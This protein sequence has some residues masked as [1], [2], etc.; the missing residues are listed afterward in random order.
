MC[1]SMTWQAC[2]AFNL[3]CLSKMSFLGYKHVYVSRVHCDSN[4]IS[5]IVQDWHIVTTHQ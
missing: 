3:N 2:V 5:E 4:N 1:V